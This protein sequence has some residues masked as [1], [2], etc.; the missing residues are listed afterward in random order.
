[1]ACENASLMMLPNPS[2]IHQVQTKNAE[3]IKLFSQNLSIK[4]STFSNQQ[5]QPIKTNLNQA[6]LLFYSSFNFQLYRELR[7]IQLENPELHLGHQ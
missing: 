7:N 1:M 5:N 4:T 2:I 6:I 3:Y